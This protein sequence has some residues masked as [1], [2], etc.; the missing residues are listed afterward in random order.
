MLVD[1][2]IDELVRLLRALFSETPLRESTI[3]KLAQGH[4]V[5]LD[6]DEY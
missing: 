1:Y 4:P 5:S 2:E 6:D 3:A